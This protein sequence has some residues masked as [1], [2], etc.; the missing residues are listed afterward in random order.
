MIMENDKKDVETLT[1]KD[2]IILVKEMR[3]NQRRFRKSSKQAIKETLEPLEIEVDDL[4]ARYLER[5][6][7]LF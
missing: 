5:Q 7:K 3:F 1:L 6:S 2:F 4:V